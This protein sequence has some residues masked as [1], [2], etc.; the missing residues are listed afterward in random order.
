MRSKSFSRL[1]SA[2][3]CLICR[4]RALGGPHLRLPKSRQKRPARSLAQALVPAHR[5]KAEGAQNDL[6]DAIPVSAITS[7]ARKPTQVRP[8]FRRCGVRGERR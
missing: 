2:Q 5:N 8:A 6:L 1:D 7:V 4:T 3:G